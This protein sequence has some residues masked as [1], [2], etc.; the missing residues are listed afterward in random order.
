MLKL[1]HN[2]FHVNIKLSFHFVFISDIRLTVLFAR[3]KQ[4]E[5]LGRFYDASLRCT[6]IR[7]LWRNMQRTFLR[8]HLLVRGRQGSHV[9]VPRYYTKC[10]DNIKMTQLCLQNP[11]RLLPEYSTKEKR[12]KV[13][14]LFN[15]GVSN[16]G[17]CRILSL[18]H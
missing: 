11:S 9:N 14:F 18:L 6:R 4:S 5:T 17:L 10:L 8:L 3:T 2:S 7:L 13:F 12:N 16:H 15:N 1:M